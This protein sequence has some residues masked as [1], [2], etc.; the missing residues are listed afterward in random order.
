MAGRTLG[1]KQAAGAEL[2]ELLSSSAALDADRTTP[3]NDGA[4]TEPMKQ[5]M[6]A[7]EQQV[8]QHATAPQAQRKPQCGPQHSTTRRPR[9]PGPAYYQP[10][11]WTGPPITRSKKKY[12]GGYMLSRQGPK[13]NDAVP[14]A[15]S[16]SE[17][18]TDPTDW[19]RTGRQVESSELFAL[20]KAKREQREAQIR[21][22]NALMQQ[23]LELRAMHCLTDTW[24]D[25]EAAAVQRSV[26]ANQSKARRAAERAEAARRN[27]AMQDRLRGIKAL[28]DADITDDV[29]VADGTVGEARARA[30]SVSRARRAAAT[31]KLASMK[32]P[33]SAA[34][35]R[36]LLEDQRVALS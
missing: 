10:E 36:P 27:R 34:S 30:T 15:G 1:L 24:L 18:A 26:M 35:P 3:T 17:S 9:S 19:R 22:G 33:S 8:A 5:E 2:D 13:L 31:G 12:G 7:A 25:D 29:D 21:E 6:Q 20:A 32:I 11:V 4:R 23:R 16:S 28:V 14:V